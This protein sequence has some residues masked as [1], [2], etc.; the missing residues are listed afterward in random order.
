MRR[1]AVLTQGVMSDARAADDFLTKHPNLEALDAFVIDVNGNARGKRVP[2][3]DLPAI[4]TAGLQFSAC[5]LIFDARG[6]GRGPA[7]LGVAD[8]DPDG[9]AVVLPGTLALVPWAKRPTTQVQLEMREA[10]TREPLWWDPRRVLTQVI[11]RCRADG[12]HPVVACELEF[13]LLESHR[14]SAGALV[15][16]GRRDAGNAALV[17]SNLSL[18]LSGDY[19]EHDENGIAAT[20]TQVVSGTTPNFFAGFIPLLDLAP[21]MTSTQYVGLYNASAG[22]TPATANSSPNCFGTH[23]RQQ[24]FTTQET[25]ITPERGEHWG[26]SLVASW[27]LG[28]TTLKSITAYREF[29]ASTEA[30]ADGTPLP[31]ASLGA[32]DRQNQ[33]SEEL[34]ATGTA[35][36]ER[37]KWTGGLY[38]LRE[39]VQ[40]DSQVRFLRTVPAVF[41]LAGLDDGTG[42]PIAGPGGPI[43]APT[44]VFF[45]ALN[46]GTV[47]RQRTESVAA[48]T[49]AGLQLTDALS[50]TLGLRYNRDSKEMLFE[51]VD[52]T[53]PP[54]GIP[55]VMN[56][57]S[58]DLKKSWNSFTPRVGLEY[59]L[60]PERMLY[61]SW[62][63]GYK[64][65]GFN[66]R[67]TTNPPRFTTYD[68]ETLN[69][70]EF[71]FKTEWLGRRLRF[72]GDFFHSKYKDIQLGTF[73]FVDGQYVTEVANSGDG[74]TK[75]AEFELAFLPHP[76]VLLSAGLGFLDFE[77]DRVND[78]AGPGTNSPPGDSLPNAP[79]YMW[80]VSAR[81]TLTQ[82]AAGETQL[83]L[84]YRRQDDVAFDVFNR[85]VQPAYG[86]LNGRLAFRSASGR[87]SVFL[88]G[89]NLTDERYANL[90]SNF[91]L[92]GLPETTFY[93]APRSW[94]AGAE[95]EF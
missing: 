45:T 85:H 9:T 13:Y 53:G 29:D 25:E 12:I 94:F 47:R 83:R 24:G 42:N 51:Q 34:Q 65:G 89:S 2:I 11:E 63:R 55:G 87:W 1:D 33:F 86:L 76:R 38:Y 79:E 48:Y 43:I 23:Y 4:C 3:A 18:T 41:P 77:Y 37:L 44:Q 49:Q 19:E 27:E 31:I 8:G 14:T 17:P 88:A 54:P 70:V 5:S 46:L 66:A 36:A 40:N 91:D 69:T 60:T 52:L 16:A 22:C 80:D 28:D 82:S 50:A 72:N 61:L 75:G 7:G 81:F 56:A 32:L 74:T 62:A 93:A 59:Q 92:F 84:D 64:S 57:T 39:H 20:N 58:P 90:I 67:P 73:L 78:V 30:G 10:G 35:I 71:G 6:T 95:Y 26:T 68:P 21:T 15:P